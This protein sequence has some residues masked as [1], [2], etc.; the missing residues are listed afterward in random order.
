MSERVQL[1]P[2]GAQ[3]L[4]G[5]CLL[6]PADQEALYS[7]ISKLATQPIQPIQ[8]FPNYG[9]FYPA[10]VTPPPS[11]ST[12]SGGWADR[13]ALETVKAAPVPKQEENK[14]EE[15]QVEDQEQEEDNS[16]DFIQVCETP[17][18]PCKYQLT[19]SEKETGEPHYPPDLTRLYLF[20]L[21]RNPGYTREDTKK[22]WNEIAFSA[23]RDNEMHDH[24]V[25]PKSRPYTAEL[26]CKNH[27]AAVKAFLNLKKDGFEV[28]WGYDKS[29][30]SNDE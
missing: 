14:V 8:L 3:V 1:S 6:P 27:K 16:A 20:A 28:N 4:A 23:R 11:A 21:K 15:K 9:T 2:Q 7:I 19:D 13:S 26:K 25:I 18:C 22:L 17:G 24:L 29:N 5:Y 12:P 10:S 30:R